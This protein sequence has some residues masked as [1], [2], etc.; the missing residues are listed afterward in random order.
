MA[1]PRE[2]TGTNRALPLGVP[3]LV[4]ETPA[5]SGRTHRPANRRQ[6]IVCGRVERGGTGN[7]EVADLCA[8]ARPE[9]AAYSRRISAGAA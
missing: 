7:V 6:R 4:E 5:G 9:S 1:G 3:P 2:T 8:A